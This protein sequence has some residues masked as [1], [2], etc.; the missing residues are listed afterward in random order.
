M[1]KNTRPPSQKNQ[2]VDE[3]RNMKVIDVSSWQADDDGNS[4]VDWQSLVDEGIE[5]V[6]I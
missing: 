5:G 3:I 4:T 6:I 2:N 1:I